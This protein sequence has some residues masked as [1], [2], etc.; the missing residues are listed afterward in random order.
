MAR[1]LTTIM[2]STILYDTLKTI[3]V[4]LATKMHQI[5][6]IFYLLLIDEG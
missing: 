6:D 1:I 4:L 5:L 2:Y 3:F